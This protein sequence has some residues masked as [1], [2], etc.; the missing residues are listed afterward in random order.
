MSCV[1]DNLEATSQVREY[2]QCVKEPTNGIDKN[3]VSVV[4]A[5]KKKWLAM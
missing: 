1:Y 4:L 3:A 5:V 2:L